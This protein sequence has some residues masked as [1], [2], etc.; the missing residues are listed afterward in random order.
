MVGRE[1][2]KKKF[3][4]TPLSVLKSLVTTR[5]GKTQV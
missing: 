3:P 4:S 2:G 1:S 5:V